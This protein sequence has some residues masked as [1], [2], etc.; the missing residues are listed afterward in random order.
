MPHAGAHSSRP[1]G[2]VA[3]AVTRGLGFSRPSAPIHGESLYG[4]TVSPHLDISCV[5]LLAFQAM[6]TGKGSLF[7]TD[8]Y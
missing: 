6:V 5:A 1:S 7:F 4:A 8:V 3:Q 2:L